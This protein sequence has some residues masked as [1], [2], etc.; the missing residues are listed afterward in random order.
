MSGF[1]LVRYILI[2]IIIAFLPLSVMAQNG[3]PAVTVYP[4]KMTKGWGQTFAVT[5]DDQGVMY[6]ADL[7]G[8]VIHD[9][10]WWEVL[11]HPEHRSP[12][13]LAYGLDGSVYVGMNND[14]AVLG[15]DSL[16]APAFISLRKHL[17][18]S[19]MQ[20][21]DIWVTS[22]TPDGIFFPG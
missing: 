17:P 22:A 5:Q 15:T 14:I 3:L 10:E 9:G 1:A 2:S 21:G 8:V 13:S 4:P 12:L 6:V 11:V 18:D 20:I 16:G 19:A 7:K